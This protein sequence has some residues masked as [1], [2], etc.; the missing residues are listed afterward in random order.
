[1][2]Y[3]AKSVVEG[4]YMGLIKIHFAIENGYFAAADVGIAVYL[5]CYFGPKS[6]A[7]KGVIAGMVFFAKSFLPLIPLS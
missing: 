2:E 4:G 1:M 3:I 5:A 7:L 6:P